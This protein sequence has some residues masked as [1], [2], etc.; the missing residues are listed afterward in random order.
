MPMVDRIR[1]IIDKEW[2]EVFKHRI[3]LF[4][5]T[6]LPAIF[7]I[8]PLVI[9]FFT[10]SSGSMS[11]DLADMP[12]QFSQVCGNM[13]SQD[14]I[15]VYLINQF[16]LLYMILPLMIPITIAAYSIVGEKTTRSLE[17]LLATPITTIELLV[18]K[19]LAAVIPAILA[20]WGCFAIF[21]LVMPV[22]GAS[23]AVQ[24]YV[25]G[26]T[27]LLAVAVIGPLMSVMAVILAVIVSS[28]VNDP[29][30]AE[31]I[32]AILI[33]P[34]MVIFFGQ[35]AGFILINLQL[36]LISIV[37]LILVDIAALYLGT[38]LFQRENILTRWK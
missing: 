25:F 28:R 34:V 1:T 6:L 13:A 24:R 5:I 33:V 8:L 38:S 19:I 2:S 17:P 3:V 36:I 22:A 12:A 16:L 31:Q 32:S 21:L 11:G 7:T 23:T 30:V 37:V 4:T 29:R 27:W 18:G 26:P 14:C 20:T 9:L 15:Q 35:L 10:R